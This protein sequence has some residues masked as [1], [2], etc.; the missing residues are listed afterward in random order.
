M[1]GLGRVS[2]TCGANGI[3]VRTWCMV[4]IKQHLVYFSLHYRVPVH[5]RLLRSIGNILIILSVRNLLRLFGHR[6]CGVGMPQQ[7]RA[8]SLRKLQS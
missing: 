4:S 7:Y 6:I 5:T 1:Y 8:Q 2:P 3:R